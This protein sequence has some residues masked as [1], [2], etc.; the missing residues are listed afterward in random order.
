[1]YC[2]VCTWV[3][4]LATKPDV[5]RVLVEQVRAL[6]VLV[7][8]GGDLRTANLDDRLFTDRLQDT[9]DAMEGK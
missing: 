2:P 9:L 3:S 6:L 1:M 8:A 5:N 7:R 4:E